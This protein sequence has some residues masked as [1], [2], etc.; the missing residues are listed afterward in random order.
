MRAAVI[1]AIMLL[2]ISCGGRSAFVL[3]IDGGAG[4]APSS[5][6]AST[7]MGGNGGFA[8]HLPCTSAEG[9]RL[10]GGNT[11]CTWLNAPECP[12]YGCTAAIELY[13]NGESTAGVC[14]ADLADKGSN[15]CVAC[16]DGEVCVY[17]APNRLVC[18]S[19]TVC[20]ALWD[21]GETDVCRYADKRAYDHQPLPT[22]IGPCPTNWYL[23]LC[24]GEC[25]DCDEM[26]ATCTGRS[27]GRP[28][29]ICIPKTSNGQH[30]T[31]ALNVDGT[32]AH[33]CPDTP[34]AAV[35]AVFD[36]PSVDVPEAR[37]YGV[38]MERD[39]CKAAAASIPGGL[40]CY[41]DKGQQL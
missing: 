16:K 30:G 34:F 17:R 4:G 41:D 21:M 13:S 26:I 12:G 35:C 29:G 20:E 11:A 36:V 39:L 33:W 1:V 38:C 24:G 9:V 18:V 37:H 10:C 27:P 19:P 23:T 3:A 40:H 7:C 2:S 25:G 5:S 31:C 22:P 14:W 8:P 32:I 15:P 6:S 28:I